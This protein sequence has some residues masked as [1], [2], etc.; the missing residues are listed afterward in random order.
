M[1]ASETKRPRNV[2]WKSA[3]AILYGDWGTSKAYVVGLAFAAAGY[4]SFWLIAAMCAL[5]ALVGMNYLILCK[6]YPEG[7]GVYASVRHRS[8]IISIVGAFLLIADYIVTAAI[9]ALSAFQYL[10]VG[11]P[12]MFAAGAILLIGGLN[13][14]GPKHTGGMAFLVAVPT[15]L[16]VVILGAFALPHMGAAIHNLQPLHGGFMENWKGFVGIVLALSG[17]EAI[18]N[19]TGVMKLDPGSSD[20]KPSVTKT[21]NKALIVVALEVCGFTALLG[22]AM[23]ALPGLEVAGGDVNA[24]G[25]EGVR[26]YMLR[27]MAQVFVGNSLGAVA[28]HIAA[29]TVSIVFGFLLLSAVNTAI[30]AL[31]SIMYLM[32]RDHEL[33]PV[34]SKLNSYGVPN[35]GMVVAAIIPMV[36]VIAV[37][38]MAGLADLY[39]VGVVGAIATNLGASATDGKLGLFRWERVMMFITFLIMLVIEI[40]LFVDKP[41]ARVF[42]VTI[43][44]IGLILRGLAVEHAKRKEKA[45]APAIATVTMPIPKFQH[46]ITTAT[47]A[48]LLCAIRGTGRTMKFAIEEA[49]ETNRPLYLLYVREQPVLAEGDRRRKWQQDPEAVRIFTEASDLADGHT[50]LPCY[51]VSDSPAD[52]IV[53]IAAT[54]G[55]SRVILGGPKR[56][57][58]ISALRGNVIRQISQLLPE[59][60]PLLVYS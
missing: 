55:A 5:T 43:L 38:D 36:L 24:P 44:A 3:A 50:V 59:E 46:E 22:L 52:T 15:M 16:V 40:S 14:F 2:D 13:Y 37:K 27:Y 20:A 21:S 49:R 30:G 41:A 57:G 7:G 34:F 54:V 8:E 23:S 39:A 42:A 11:H 9:S 35:A 31:I 12:E 51:A 19:S 33:P 4:S 53:D 45:E 1:I 25:A 18:A 47:G 28:G 17:V 60:I 56:S 10:G 58:L 48:P 32:S 29:W 26:D 6:H